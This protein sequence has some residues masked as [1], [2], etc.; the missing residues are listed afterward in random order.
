LITHFEISLS[1]RIVHVGG[2]AGLARYPRSLLGSAQSV[3]AGL[4]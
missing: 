3:K 1:G 4:E 2:G